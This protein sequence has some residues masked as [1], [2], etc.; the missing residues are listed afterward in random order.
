M[1]IPEHLEDS[2]EST[3][4]KVGDS[5]P[6]SGPVPQG[7]AHPPLSV[8]PKLLG[9][10]RPCPVKVTRLPHQTFQVGRPA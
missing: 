10:Y 3:S 4:L 2:A 5:W 7:L 1:L 8:T 6:G 9:S